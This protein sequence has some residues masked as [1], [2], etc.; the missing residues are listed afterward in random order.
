MTDG[1]V[2][3]GMIGRYVI[4]SYR[5]GE[6]ENVWVYRKFLIRQE[7]HPSGV[8]VD[9]GGFSSIEAV[10]QALHDISMRRGKPPTRAND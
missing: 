3:S 2:L 9:S 6:V 5:C 1:P 8:T 4:V 10:E 7:E